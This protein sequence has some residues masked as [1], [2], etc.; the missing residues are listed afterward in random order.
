MSNTKTIRLTID[1]TYEPESDEPLDVKTL[2]NNL[3]YIADN[4]AN[5]GLMSQ[6][7]SALVTEWHATVS[8]KN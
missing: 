8:E 3:R 7:T 4:A 2:S 1:V 6:G 5:H